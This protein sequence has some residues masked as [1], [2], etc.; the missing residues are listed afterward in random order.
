MSGA[1]ALS[2]MVSVT[3]WL[4]LMQRLEGS[5]GVMQIPAEEWQGN[6]LL[7]GW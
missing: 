3:D 2:G 5:V 7:L 6:K 1:F 4:M